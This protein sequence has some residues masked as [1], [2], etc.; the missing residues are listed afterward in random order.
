MRAQ[1]PWI[2]MQQLIN[3]WRGSGLRRAW[4]WWLG[5]L[6]ACLPE[7]WT[8]KPAEQLYQWPLAEPPT[9][10]AG[11]VQAVL[12]LQP[13][14]ALV[15]CLTLPL[16]ARHSLHNVLA[17]EL[18]RFT[19]LPA[20]RVHYRVHSTRLSAGR[21]H[22]TLVVVRREHMSQWLDTFSRHGIAL[23]RIDLL[24]D[25]GQ[26]LGTQLLPDDALQT[27][28]GS[29]RRWLWAGAGLLVLMWVAMALTLHDREQVLASRT[30]EVAQQRAAASELLGLRRDLEQAGGAERYLDDLKQ[31]QPTRALLLAELSACL[32]ASTWLQSLQI[33]KQGQVDLAGFSADASSLI[34]QIKQCPHLTDAQ[35]QGIIQPD[36]VSGKDR[37]YL[38]AQASR[39]V[40]HAALTIG[41]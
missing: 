16:A 9:P 26:R 29:G 4:Q 41:P 23:A 36:A 27:S 31:Q 22:V 1:L 10:P 39:G 34:N 40:E 37:F 20:E 7:H 11:S 38:R 35:Y 12:L 21:L 33:N 30:L 8:R 25:Q 15:H 19:P 14:Q 5:Q 6:S 18:D 28:T 2:G 24:N 17:F 13:D 3:R 32:P